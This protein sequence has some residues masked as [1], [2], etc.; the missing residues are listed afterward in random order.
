MWML[1]LH[2]TGRIPSANEILFLLIG[3]GYKN[4]ANGE[5]T[6]ESRGKHFKFFIFLK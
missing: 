4:I 1:Q 5:L 2:S 3:R 6:Q